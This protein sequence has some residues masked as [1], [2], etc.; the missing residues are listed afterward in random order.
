MLEKQRICVK[1]ERNVLLLSFIVLGEH[2]VFW[3]N[4]KS[5]TVT[6]NREKHLYFQICTHIIALAYLYLLKRVN[7]LNLRELKNSCK[8]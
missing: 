1:A 5:K 4:K 3:P 7:R 2:L 8:N 6:L